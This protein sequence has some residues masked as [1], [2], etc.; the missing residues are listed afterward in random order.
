MLPSNK[1]AK[2]N[3]AKEFKKKFSLELQLNKFKYSIVK[4]GNTD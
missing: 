1:L 3:S 2:Q 4:K